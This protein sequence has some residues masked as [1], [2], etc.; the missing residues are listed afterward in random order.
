MNTTDECL[1]A[2][3]CGSPVQMPTRKFSRGHAKRGEA[4]TSLPEIVSYGKLTIVS[5]VWYENKRQ[6][7]TVQCFCGKEFPARIN[8]LKTGNTTSCG[9]KRSASLRVRNRTHG[10]APRSGRHPLYQTWADI[11]QR[12]T[13]RNHP[14]YDDY[15][16]RGISVCCE[17]LESFAAFL[18]SVG[19]RP[20]AKAEIDRKDNNGNYEPGNIRWATRKQQTSNTR[21]NH[22]VTHRGRTQTLQAWAEELRW[23]QAG[24][25]YR[26]KRM[27]LEVALVRNPRPKEKYAR[28]T[29]VS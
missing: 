11:V 26:V 27:P 22:L 4:S 1:C 19:E 13:N 17:W 8:A 25:A 15:G 12:C 3:G 21:N 7:A 23:S 24:M 29:P 9:C 16:G 14:K 28:E 20:F 2:C 6:M 10:L 18:A 5:P